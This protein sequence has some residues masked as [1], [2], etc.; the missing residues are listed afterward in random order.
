MGQQTTW[1]AT[2]SR[3]AAEEEAR[4]AAVEAKIEEEQRLHGELSDTNSSG[5][6]LYSDDSDGDEVG[7]STGVQQS[8][9]WKRQVAPDRYGY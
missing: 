1:E 7:R 4:I 5:S 6:D 3:A 2:V 8:T 9:A